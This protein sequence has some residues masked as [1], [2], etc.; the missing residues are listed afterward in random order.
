MHVL[1]SRVKSHA[2]GR[3][4]AQCTESVRQRV[5]SV[6][7]IYFPRRHKRRHRKPRLRAGSASEPSARPA[8]A[9]VSL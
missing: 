6:L 8:P 7:V 4:R 5:L 3:W 2:Y 1:S 9:A